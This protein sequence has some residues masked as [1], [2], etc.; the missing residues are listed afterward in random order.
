MRLRLRLPLL[1]LAAAPLAAQPGPQPGPRAAPAAAVDLF[2]LAGA[3]KVNAEVRAADDERVAA[4]IAADRARLDAVL[5]EGL[6]YGHSNGAVDG[7]AAFVE[8]LASRRVAYESVDYLRRD[9]LIAGEDIVLMTG[10]A[11]VRAGLTG[12]TNELDLSFLAVWR[13]EAGRWRFL[14][15]QS[16][17]NPPPAPPPPPAVRP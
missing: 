5:S 2:T 9:F 8:S 17:R 13:R 6:H 7:K 10:R 14:A 1:V 16:S 12:R 11:R 4:M 3:E 15:W